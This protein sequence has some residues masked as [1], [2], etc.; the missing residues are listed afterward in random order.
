[1]QQ[2]V[3]DF[4]GVCSLYVE[5]CYDR[6]GIQAHYLMTP[7]DAGS[8]LAGSQFSLDLA[9]QYILLNS[10]V[11]RDFV[12]TIPPHC[13]EYMKDSQRESKYNA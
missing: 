10:E 11:H 2:G 5:L 6:V 12:S 13:P 1:M 4:H 8:S 7:S 3:H 9:K